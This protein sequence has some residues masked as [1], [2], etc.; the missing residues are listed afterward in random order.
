MHL[1]PLIPNMPP[2]PPRCLRLII[3]PFL[4]IIASG[5]QQ[6]TQRRRLLHSS[7]LQRPRPPS[8]SLVFLLPSFRIL[9]ILLVPRQLLLSPPLQCN[10]HPNHDPPFNPLQPSSPPLF[11]C[12]HPLCQL[13]VSQ[14][15]TPLS[16]RP[17]ASHLQQHQWML[18]PPSS[19]PLLQTLPQPLLLPY[20][21]PVV[22]LDQR[23]LRQR[24]KQSLR[25]HSELQRLVLRPQP[26]PPPPNPA[27]ELL[28]ILDR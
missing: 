28:P 15:P 11:T 27:Q 8:P 19:V 12:P 5:R 20:P 25:H 26:R 3:L 14:Q 7:L 4:R 10:D 17:P 9:Q 24:C 21:L 13:L 6:E 23:R 22:K 2:T 18:R 16:H 1:S